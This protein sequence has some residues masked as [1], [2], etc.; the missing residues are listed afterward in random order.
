MLWAARG[1]HP[2]QDHQ[3]LTPFPLW[4]LRIPSRASV[5]PTLGTVPRGRFMGRGDFQPFCAAADQKTSGSLWAY[6]LAK[7]LEG[8]RQQREWDRVL[9]SHQSHLH[10]LAG[11]GGGDT[12]WCRDSQP[13]TSGS[14]KNSTTFRCCTIPLPPGA[15]PLHSHF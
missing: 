6:H 10:I 13:L 8:T 2:A 4:L 11:H 14:A 7:A 12:W 9:Q 1:S 5:P 15:Q 3:K